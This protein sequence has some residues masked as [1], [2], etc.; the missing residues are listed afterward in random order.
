MRMLMMLTGLGARLLKLGREPSK[1]GRETE[2]DSRVAEALAA[3]RDTLG[4]CYRDGV[5]YSLGYRTSEG[6]IELC[7]EVFTSLDSGI[8]GGALAALRRHRQNFDPGRDVKRIIVALRPVRVIEPHR[9]DG[10]PSYGLEPGPLAGNPISAEVWGEHV[11]NGRF[12]VVRRAV[13]MVKQDCERRGVDISKSTVTISVKPHDGQEAFARCEK[14][15]DTANEDVEH[16]GEMQ[17]LAVDDD[18][19]DDYDINDLLKGCDPCCECSCPQCECDGTCDPDFATSCHRCDTW[20]CGFC[21][22]EGACHNCFS[23]MQGGVN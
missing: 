20:V 12:E 2:S 1:P 23:K 3:M 13:D 22:V 21:V 6:V 17:V 7:G 8:D 9:T 14:S 19:D 15:Y 5:A 11:A 16:M 10:T 18:N 4:G